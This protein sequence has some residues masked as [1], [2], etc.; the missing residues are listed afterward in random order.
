MCNWASTTN[1]VKMMHDFACL[2]FDSD[3]RFLVDKPTTTANATA[4]T[5]ANSTTPA[6]FTYSPS[7]LETF[8]IFLCV[9]HHNRALSRWNAL[10]PSSLE[11]YH[12]TIA[13]LATLPITDQ[14]THPS[15]VEAIE[16]LAFAA[17]TRSPLKA[18]LLAPAAASSSPSS[19]STKSQRNSSGIQTLPSPTSMLTSQVADVLRET[20]GPVLRDAD[21]SV[22]EGWAIPAPDAASK[23]TKLPF[24]PQFNT[25]DIVLRRRSSSGNAAND[26]RDIV[27]IV[28]I[29]D[30]RVPC[31]ASADNDHALDRDDAR[32]HAFVNHDLIRDVGVDLEPRF[33]PLGP[34]PEPMAGAR[35]H[36]LKR[37]LYRQYLP[38]VPIFL[39][40]VKGPL[41]VVQLEAGESSYL[42]TFDRETP[43]T[44]TASATQRADSES[45]RWTEKIQSEV[46]Y[47]PRGYVARA[48][49]R[50][51][52]ETQ[53]RV[54][55]WAAKRSKASPVSDASIVTTMENLRQSPAVKQAAAQIR[56]TILAAAASSQSPSVSPSASIKKTAAP[57]K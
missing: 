17:S 22:H 44:A 29:D 33:A 56:E 39:V 23:R 27:A 47:D 53:I 3:W 41:V 7:L 25:T 8:G 51:G 14:W 36:R 35:P 20:L 4:T 46:L 21:V 49:L 38:H 34:P 28:E 37:H 2:S 11:K 31:I 5:T 18:S 50:H 9:L 24:A 48:A 6:V 57:R 32:Y 52:G 12:Q 13:Y 15:F 43:L 19:S 26:P 30:Q 40:E 55:S 16:S 54:A 1:V 10:S 45:P 42:D